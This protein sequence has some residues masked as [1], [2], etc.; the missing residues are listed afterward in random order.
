MQQGAVMDTVAVVVGAVGVLVGIIA[1][2]KAGAAAQ[3]AS[4]AQERAQE[5]LDLARRAMGGAEAQL[6]APKPEPVSKPKP[7]LEPK[8]ELDPE[9]EPELDL[10][11]EPEPEP[12]GLDPK[13][14]L[15][16][17]KMVVDARKMAL[18]L[19]FD[20]MYEVGDRSGYKVPIQPETDYDD[21]A[22]AYL[23]QCG[24]ESILDIEEKDGETFLI[25]DTSV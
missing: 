6:P 3:Q 4:V 22:I 1:L 12:A 17:E 24:D 5:A 21:E 9:P 14:V 13:V 10:E 11:P 7:E 20:N 2:L 15:R 23:R 25:L 16:A 8:P 19:G 18:H